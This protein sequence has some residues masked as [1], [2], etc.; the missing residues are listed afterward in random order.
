M[1]K[2]RI[3]ITTIG[4]LTSSDLIYALRKN[5]EREVE[6]FGLD[7]FEW[8]VCKTMVDHFCICPNSTEDEE[9]FAN[10]VNNY[11]RQ[12]AIDI[13]IPCGNED[14]LALAKY[15]EKFQTPILVGS[16]NSLIKAYDKGAVYDFLRDRLPQH[17]PKFKIVKNLQEFQEALAFLNFPQNKIVIKPRFGRGGRGV[18]IIGNCFNFD[19]FFHKKPENEVDI[20]TIEAIL[21]QQEN[22]E[23]LIVMEYLTSPFL[24]AYSLCYQGKNILTLKHIREWGNASQTYRGLVSYDEDMEKLC[25][26]V[27]EIFNLTY[28]NNMELAFN[29]NGNIVL[30][31]LNPRIGASSA[32]DTD[33]GFNFPYLA[34][35]LL[36]QE[37]IKINKELLPTQ[38][39]FLRYFS[40][41][42]LK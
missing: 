37:E 38:S 9:I 2:L 10:F 27:I 41:L 17:A 11:A 24:S 13:I 25:S 28:T 8:A 33:I 30:F 4:G 42:W 23:E 5:K 21:K 1:K 29:Q 35:K 6:L 34:I 18:Y 39:R 20:K 19:N 32:I 15:K 16:Y 40:Y 22:F 31:D 26:K 12:N 3:L 36:L 14:N 7:A